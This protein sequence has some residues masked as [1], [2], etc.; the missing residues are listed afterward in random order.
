M[1]GRITVN[2]ELGRGSIFKVDLPLPPEPQ[3]AVKETL[4]G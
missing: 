1:G 4:A 3:S 2:S